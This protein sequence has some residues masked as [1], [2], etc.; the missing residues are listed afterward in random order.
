MN[1]EE[2]NFLFTLNQDIKKESVIKSKGNFMVKYKGRCN[3][4]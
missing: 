4:C 1:L 2:R 3:D